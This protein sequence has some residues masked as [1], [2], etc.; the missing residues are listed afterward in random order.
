VSTVCFSSLQ[1]PLVP[2]FL[3]ETSEPRRARFPAR[4]K[5]VTKP[6]V[7]LS[8]AVSTCRCLCI[9]PFTCWSPIAQAMA[10][11]QISQNNT[12]TFGSEVFLPSNMDLLTSSLRTQVRILCN[13]RA[14]VS[15]IKH[16]MSQDPKNPADSCRVMYM[17]LDLLQLQAASLHV[18]HMYLVPDP[19]YVSCCNVPV[20]RADSCM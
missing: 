1:A 12:T 3:K 11:P 2:G 9:L 7:S 16:S 18:R 10:L 5:N 13:C 20:R 8:R 17:H 19:A 6:R 4:A 15:V 14:Y